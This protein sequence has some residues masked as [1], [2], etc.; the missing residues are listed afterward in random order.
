MSA[1]TAPT[2]ASRPPMT[3]RYG[4][5]EMKSRTLFPR[6]WSWTTVRTWYTYKKP[7]TITATP[8]TR[9]ATFHHGANA[10]TTTSSPST[11]T[12]IPRL[13]P[14]PGTFTEESMTNLA[15]IVYAVRAGPSS[16]VFAPQFSQ[17]ERAASTPPITMRDRPT[18]ALRV[19]PA[20]AVGVEDM[21]TPVGCAPQGT[22]LKGGY[23][24]VT[25]RNAYAV[26]RKLQRM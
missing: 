17:L 23:R 24:S 2:T 26:T 4:P 14:P 18:V 16:R 1:I 5:I 19:V 11:S 21:A 12:T 20:G 7:V 25:S 13:S 9:P 6:L 22:R 15:G 3:I 10:A 8:S